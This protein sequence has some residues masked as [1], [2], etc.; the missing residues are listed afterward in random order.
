MPYKSSNLLNDLSNIFG[1][2]I[3]KTAYNIF[4]GFYFFVTIVLYFS[5][6]KSILLD[7]IINKTEMY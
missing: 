4:E 7:V 5:I 6:L 2:H 1:Q 3:Y